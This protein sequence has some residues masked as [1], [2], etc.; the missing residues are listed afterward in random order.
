MF[1]FSFF[2]Y[3]LY[4]KK[5]FFKPML[6]HIVLW[7]FKENAEGGS[8]AENISAVKKMLEGLFGKIPEIL[9]IHVRKNTFSFA[10]N[11]DVALIAEFESETELKAYQAHPLHV[12][13][14]AFVKK[15]TEARAA[16]DYEE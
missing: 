5:S 16:V 4:T 13:A 8:A 6:K 12:E 11:Y 3:A 15:V 2:Q 14:A 10:G 7:K 1:L 9:S